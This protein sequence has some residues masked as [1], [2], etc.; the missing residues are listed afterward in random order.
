M[1]SIWTGKQPVVPA[2][3]AASKPSAP[4]N[5]DVEHECVQVMEA[6]VE[7]F[8]TWDREYELEGL[9]RDIAEKEKKDMKLAWNE[10]PPHKQLRD[11]LY[12]DVSC[13][14]ITSSHITNILYLMSSSVRCF[15]GVIIL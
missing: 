11:Y 14:L 8:N 10:N 15:I 4:H 13:A 1:Y 12:Q 6:C 3:L 7:I 9:L 5:T 2:I